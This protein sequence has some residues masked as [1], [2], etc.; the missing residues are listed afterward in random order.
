[1][2]T[3]LRNIA[4]GDLTP[5]AQGLRFYS[6]ELRESVFHRRA[7]YPSGKPAGDA[8]YD[9]WDSLHTQALNGYGFPATSRPTSSISPE[10]LVVGER[11]EGS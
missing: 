2:V 1:M 5:V 9:L 8:G 3:R 6:H 4:S 7:G 10:R 11:H